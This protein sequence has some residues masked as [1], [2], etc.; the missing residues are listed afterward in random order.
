MNIQLVTLGSIILL[1]LILAFA[2]NLFLN[3]RLKKLQNESVE[4]YSYF[5]IKGIFF[6]S[7]GILSFNLYEV[8]L[9]LNQVLFNNGSFNEVVIQNLKY[10]SIF[11]SFS[12]IYL[13][14]LYILSGGLYSLFQK[15]SLKKIIDNPPAIIMYIA[16][17]LMLV[18][19]TGKGIYL[20][21]E[22]WI[23]YPSMPIY[24]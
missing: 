5:L 16:I 8:F 1:I 24:R 4:N 18:L 20:I 9:T 14:I 19:S 15:I 22:L 7:A 12:L 6:I 10:L 23:P 2:I 17:V 11:G 21:S 13:I 3:W